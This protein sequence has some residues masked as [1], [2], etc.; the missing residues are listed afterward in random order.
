[1]SDCTTGSGNRGKGLSYLSR[2]TLLSST[3]IG[4][5]ALSTMGLPFKS[6]STS[7]YKMGWPARSRMRLPAL[8]TN[9]RALLLRM[10][11]PF[12]SRIGTPF[13]SSLTSH[14]SMGLPSLPRMGLPAVSRTTWSWQTNW[15]PTLKSVPLPSVRGRLSATK[16]GMVPFMIGLPFLS[17]RTSP[18]KM[19]MPAASR[20]GAPRGSKRGRADLV[21]MTLPFLSRTGLSFLSSMTPSLRMG[22]PSK[23]ISAVPFLSSTTSHWNT[24]L[25]FT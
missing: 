13:L 23:F 20:R 9:G 7:P 3:K 12:L 25:P 5:P 15:P 17:R 2:M 6:R 21:M 4:L 19:G 11:P 16:R 14:K 10:T 22:R 18:H 24:G 8:S 1:M